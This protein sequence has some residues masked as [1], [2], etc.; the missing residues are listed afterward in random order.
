MSAELRDLRLAPLHWLMAE[1]LQDT[2]TK[3]RAAVDQ[4]SSLMPQ[5]AALLVD[6]GAVAAKGRR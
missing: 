5:L 2:D 4:L 1:F 3:R 6:A